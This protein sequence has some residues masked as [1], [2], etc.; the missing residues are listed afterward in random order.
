MHSTKVSNIPRRGLNIPQG[1]QIFDAAA[2]TFH[3]G[4]KYSMERVQYST[5]V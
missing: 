4:V 1:W 5:E 3:G 2:Q